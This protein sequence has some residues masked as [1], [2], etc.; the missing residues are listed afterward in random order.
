MKITVV[1]HSSNGSTKV[2]AGHIASGARREGA[3]VSCISILEA[4]DNLHLLHNADTIVFGSPTSLGSVSAAFKNFM[5]IT[6][7][8]HEQQ[9]W[10]NKL[11]AGFTSSSAGSGDKLATLISL[12]LFAAQHSMIW[13]SAG[14]LSGQYK[15][16]APAGAEGCLGFMAITEN[17]GQLYTPLGMEKAELFGRR[18]A[19]ITNQFINTKKIK[20]ETATFFYQ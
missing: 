14:L 13:I 2:T 18:I 3:D 6:S 20:N 12:S 10:K 15:I 11:A 9:L 7:R 8:F 16:A 1:Y 19:I 4:Q 17:N 5:E